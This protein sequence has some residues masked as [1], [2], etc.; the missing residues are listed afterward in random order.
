[1]AMEATHV[2]FALELAGVLGVKDLRAYLS[3]AVYPDSR[4]LTGVARSATH[5]EGSPQD[6]FASGLSDFERGWATH[7]VYDAHTSELA[8]C[9]LDVL[10]PD[11]WQAENW[12]WP[13][14][15]ARKLVEELGTC[16]LMGE[17]VTVMQTL[18]P[19][20]YP[21]GENREVMEKYYEIQRKGYEGQVTV[22]TAVHTL[23]TAGVEEARLKA[24][25]EVAR[26][27]LHHQTATG[28]I[29]RFYGE[30]LTAVCPFKR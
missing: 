18:E 20:E 30:T 5:A 23:Q 19:V 26:W 12:R 7:I 22:E 1:M 16:R 10:L 11:A 9:E 14:V 15:T 29:Y 13:W 21:F 3:G 24:V 17:R 27:M 4:Y 6:P 2:R 28:I 8:R 25:E